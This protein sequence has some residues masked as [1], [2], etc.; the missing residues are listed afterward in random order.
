MRYGGT[1]NPNVGYRG[2]PFQSQKFFHSFM[3][4][5]LDPIA[6]EPPSTENQNKESEQG[7]LVSRKGAGVSFLDTKAANAAGNRKG[8]VKPAQGIQSKGFAQSGQC[9]ILCM[10]PPRLVHSNFFP[11]VSFS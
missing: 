2:R 10:E 3:T 1:A 9:L 7:K 4:H 11:N 8:Y 5:P 6:N